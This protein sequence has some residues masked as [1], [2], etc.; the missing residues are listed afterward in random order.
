MLA[1]TWQLLKFWSCREMGFCSLKLTVDFKHRELRGR[2]RARDERAE[3]GE[4]DEG[5]DYRIEHVRNQGQLLNN[6]IAHEEGRYEYETRGMRD[7]NPGLHRELER[8]NNE[9]YATTH[10][11]DED[12]EESSGEDVEESEEKEEDNDDDDDDDDEEDSDMDI[13][14]DSDDDY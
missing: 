5:H 10:Q 14:T 2:E 9:R 3:F 13:E 7:V 12:S 8:E 6:S 1:A 4:D 11:S